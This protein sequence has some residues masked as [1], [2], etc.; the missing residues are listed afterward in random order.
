M[1][2]ITPL[3]RSSLV[4]INHN[5]FLFHKMWLPTKASASQTD[6]YSAPYDNTSV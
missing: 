4:N 1:S 3:C 6:T 2:K 5:T